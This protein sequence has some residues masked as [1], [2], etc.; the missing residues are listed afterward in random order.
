M[1]IIPAI[2]LKEGK[3]VRLLQGRENALTVYSEDP[4]S[5]ARLWES[6]GARLLHVIDLDG[7]FT[8]NQKNLHAIKRIRESVAMEREGGGGVRDLSKIDELISIGINRII[9]GTVAIEKPTL[10][11]EACK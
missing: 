6:Y 3:C 8:G 10:L 1:L 11:N 9:L 4:V 7:A 2:D 5:T